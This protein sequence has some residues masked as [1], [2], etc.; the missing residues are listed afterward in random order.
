MLGSNSHEE[1]TSHDV[2]RNFHSIQFTVQMDT[3]VQLKI[4]CR[5]TMMQFLL[6]YYENTLGHMTFIADILTRT[7][8]I[9]RNTLWS[10]EIWLIDS[11]KC[12][13]YNFWNHWIFFINITSCI[14]HFLFFFFIPFLSRSTI[15]YT[16]VLTHMLNS[17]ILVHYY[18]YQL[19]SQWF[20]LNQSLNQ[21]FHDSS[22]SK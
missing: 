15:I 5:D 12:I 7:P 1:M 11:L 13:L 8:H 14:V 3:R 10:N 9:V 6:L 17:Y 19:H 20:N 22:I 16:G 18:L 21:F 4:T 2:P